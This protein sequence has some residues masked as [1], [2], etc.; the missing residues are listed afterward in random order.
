MAPTQN[1]LVE[2]TPKM[3][4]APANA[5]MNGQ[6]S[7]CTGTSALRIDCCRLIAV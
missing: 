2:K 4:A 5:P 3:I 6:P 1:R 7:R